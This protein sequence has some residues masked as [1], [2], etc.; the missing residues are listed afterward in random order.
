MIA[1]GVIGL[2]MLAC[3]VVFL[4]VYVREAVSLPDVEEDM[5]EDDWRRREQ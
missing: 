5:S 4:M 3:T 1:A 2:V